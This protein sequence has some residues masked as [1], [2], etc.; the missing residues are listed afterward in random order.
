MRFYDDI[1]IMVCWIRLK[2]VPWYAYELDTLNV[3]EV[4]LI[5]VDYD[6]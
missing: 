3:N 1:L 5:K 6:K 2:C 4:E